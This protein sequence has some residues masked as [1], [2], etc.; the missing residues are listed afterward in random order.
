MDWPSF[1]AGT[2]HVLVQACEACSRQP[3]LLIVFMQMPLE[4]H[5]QNVAHTRH[6]SRLKAATYAQH[7]DDDGRLDEVI[8]VQDDSEDEQVLLLVLHVRRCSSSA[9]M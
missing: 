8:D 2:K 1:A 4:E 9:C 5:D 7:S 6:P 3:S